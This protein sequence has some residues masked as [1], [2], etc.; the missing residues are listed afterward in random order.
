MLSSYTAVGV[1]GFYTIV[2]VLKSYTA[3]GCARLLSVI[4][5]PQYRIYTSMEP[6]TPTFL[7]C[8]KQGRATHSLFAG[9]R[10]QHIHI[11]DAGRIEG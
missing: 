5:L 1:L 9:S 10:K 6:Q 8:L 4:L 7:S 11:K 2:G 3:M